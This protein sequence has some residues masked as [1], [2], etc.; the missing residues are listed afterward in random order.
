MNRPIYRHLADKKWRQYHR[1]LLI[2]RISQHHIVPDLLS[3]LDPTASVTLGFG[4][5]NVQPGQFVDS[6]VSEVP[7]RL[8]VQVFDKGERLVTVVV[9]NPDVPD[10]EKDSFKSR[11]HFLAANVPI[12][13]TSTSVALTKLSKDHHVI[14]PW[15]PPYAQKGSPHHRLVVFVLQQDGSTPLDLAQLRQYQSQRENWTLKSLLTKNQ[16]L[17]PIGVNIFRTIWD[18][19]TD[20]VMKRAGVEGVEVEYVRKQPEKNVYKKKDGAR[21]R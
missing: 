21:Y 5:R 1:L 20:G 14:Q 4:R 15:L 11:C 6:R 17:R 13:P 19:G 12:S 16:S 8:K 2:Q 3:H 9:V 10:L 7:A 18:E